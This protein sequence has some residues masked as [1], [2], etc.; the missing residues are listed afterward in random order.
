MAAVAIVVSLFASPGGQARDERASIDVCAECHRGAVESY[1]KHGMFR[2]VAPAGVV[3][4]GSVFNPRSGSRYALSRSGRRTLLTATFR[5]GGTRRQRIVGRIGAGIFSTSWV[6]EELNPID[7]SETGR[8]FFAPVESVSGV[9]LTLAPFEL[10]DRSPGVDQELTAACLTCHTLTRSDPAPFP[11]NLLGGDLFERIDALGCDTCHGDT[12]RH[13]TIVK[14][15]P[16]APNGDPGLVQLRSLSPG[17]RRDVCARC[18]LQGDARIELGTGEPSWERP[19]A[20]QIAVVVPRAGGTD[21]RFVGQLER[22]AMSACF[23][24]SPAMTCN[25]CHWPHSGVAAQG[26]D[27]FDAACVSCHAVEPAHAKVTPMQVTGEQ[28]RTEAGCVDCHLR[29]SAPFDLPNVRTADHFIRRRIE[30]PQLQVTH[31]QFA[32]PH[33]EVAV[34]D[35]G[36]LAAA[37][38]TPEGRRWEAGVVGMAML[39]MGRLEEA[40]E[41]FDRLPPPGTRSPAGTR[42]PGLTPVESTTVFHSMRALALM[43]SGRLEAAHAALGDA[44]ALDAQTPDALLT[45]AQLRLDRGDIRGALLDTEMVI[46]AYPMAEQP[47]NLRVAVAQRA[48]RSDLA[49]SAARASLRIWPSNPRGW[50]LLSRLLRERGDTAGAEQALQQLRALAPSLMGATPESR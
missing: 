15:A 18:H 5:D 46:K 33:G 49:L 16:G 3:P 37:L 29:R 28:A 13:L 7:G 24:K 10:H 39:T 20:G 47:W 11:A 19:L 23:T 38:R 41:R 44:L 25:T 36:R 27:S 22:L 35:D 45:R 21:F 32:D 4:L 14:G 43:A 1:R 17:S 34:F 26:T 31:R 40:A 30:R 9:G 6:S 8:L 50:L 2:S 48:G 42:P 12:R